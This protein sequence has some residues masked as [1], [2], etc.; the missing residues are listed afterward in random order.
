MSTI[1]YKRLIEV[2]LLHDY[3]LSKADLTS[4]YALDNNAQTDFLNSSIARDEYDVR[5]YL[6]I[7]PLQSTRAIFKNYHL[8]MVPTPSGFIVGVKV[9]IRR[10]AA[11][12]EEYVPTIEPTDPLELGFRLRRKKPDFN[13]YT[14]LRIRQSSPVHYF[15]SNINPDGVK[16]FPSLSLPVADF[17]AGKTYE[18]GELAVVGGALQQALEETST[19]D[20]AVWKPIAGSG[21]VNEQDRVLLPKLFSHTFSEATSAA[22]ITLKKT[23]GTK[24]KSVEP[25]NIEAFQTVYLDFRQTESSPAGEREEIDDGLYQLEISGDLSTETKPVYL[26]DELYQRTD[27]GALVIGTGI[28]DTDFKILNSDGTLVTKKRADGSIVPHPVY[29]LRFKRR[30][31]YWR[32]RSDTGGDL[33]ATADTLPFLV[34]DDRDLITK[35]LRPL[36]YYP[37]FFKNPP[38]PDLHLPNPYSDSINKKEKKYYS[39]MYV[40]PI[41]GLIELE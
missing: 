19:D 1:L 34:E 14:N 11:G 8:R 10:N 36:T 22:E 35:D 40:S 12:E 7:I 2:H 6:E 17:Q 39:D 5:N 21:F 31:T 26:S 41:K 15:F 24:L 16:V 3:Y 20:A 38:Q 27:V 9:K 32:Y 33:K 4:F 30:S 23:D 29:E 37:T 13:T 18:T 28:T 25:K